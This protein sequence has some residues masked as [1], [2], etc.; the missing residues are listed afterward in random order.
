MTSKQEGAMDVVLVGLGGTGHRVLLYMKALLAG[1]EVADRFRL[2]ALDTDA[3]PLVVPDLRTGRPLSLSPDHEFFALGNV[4]VDRLRQRLD[5]HPEIAR[6]LPMLQ[7]LPATILRRGARQQRPLGALAFLWHF[8]PIREVI[9]HLLWTI[10]DRRISAGSTPGVFIVLITSLCGGTGAGMFLDMAYLLRYEL[11]NTGDLAQRSIIVLLAV[12]PNAFHNV[13]GPNLIPNCVASLLELNHWM[14]H[15][16]FCMEYRDGTRV[17]VDLPPYDLVFYVDAVDEGGYTWPDRE[18]LTRALAEALLVFTATS[19]GPQGES[20]LENLYSV[21]GHQTPNGE[22]TFLGSLGAASLELPVAALM[23]LMATESVRQC[24]ERILQPFVSPDLPHRYIRRRPW[25]AEA[26]LTPGGLLRD[27]SGSPLLIRLT[28][29]AWLERLPDPEELA[30]EARRYLEDYRQIRLDG[31]FRAAVEAAAREWE[32]RALEDMEAEIH[33][34]FKQHGLPAAQSFL[35]ALRDQCAKLGGELEEARQRWRTGEEG[36]ERRL[37]EEARGLS[38]LRPLAWPLIGWLLR[39]FYL[40][41]VLRRTFTT[42]EEFARVR[43]NRVALDCAQAALF[44]LRESLEAWQAELRRL[45]NL[46]RES[47]QIL[48][49]RIDRI[50]GKL[51]DPV[52]PPALRMVD[53]SLLQ[54]LEVRSRNQSPMVDLATLREWSGEGAALLVERWVEYARPIFSF[55]T[56]WTLEEL[57][58][59]RPGIAP[60]KRLQALRRIARPAWQLDETAWPM[61]GS[62]VRLELIGVADATNTRFSGSG[63]QLVSTGDPHRVIAL[64]LAIGAP[65]SGLRLF[66]QYF[67]AYQRAQSR[68][69]LHIFPNFP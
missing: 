59:R 5:Q 27:E 69:L 11:Q 55:L 68:D 24:I 64:S 20:A 57:L 49:D 23:E 53:E 1:Q 46:L 29:P 33:Q 10:V 56:D 15:G 61:S 28:V 67:Q 22:G 21:L 3:E 19:L 47:L 63:V 25:S 60:Q 26:L 52:L 40:A 41:P 12:G 16:N 50:R 39:R 9:H 2:L 6:R 32:R 34:L 14:L 38:P 17:E 35:N 8:R 43:L 62:L 65:I 54:E 18:A 30:R 45:E 36:L 51:L 13:R 58:G 37:Q 48:Q 4:P 42:A 31:D 66:P 44:R 7:D